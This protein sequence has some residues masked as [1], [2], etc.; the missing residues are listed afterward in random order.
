MD[1]ILYFYDVDLVHTG[2]SLGDSVHPG[3]RIIDNKYL[4]PTRL[5]KTQRIRIGERRPFGKC[6]TGP[7]LC[8]LDRF[9]Y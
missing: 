7:P 1:D 5:N 6:N 2:L 8:P 9:C 3:V 4:Q